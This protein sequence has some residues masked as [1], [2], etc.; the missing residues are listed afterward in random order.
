MSLI[1]W[2]IYNIFDYSITVE[3]PTQI[4]QAKKQL[5]SMY[6]YIEK[7]TGIP[8]SFIVAHAE[9]ES[10]QNPIARGALGEYGLW[11]FL[12]K[13]WFNLMPSTDWKNVN[14][15][16]Q[17]YIK[18][19]KWIISSLGLNMKKTT[20]REKFLWV[21]NAGIGNYRRNVLPRSTKSYIAKVL[22]L[23]EKIV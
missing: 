23:E 4:V 18:H 13:V 1:N 15:Q 19:A 22:N 12:P 10:N 9:A 21:W 20:D 6:R 16:A 8:Y 7:E 3:K 14:N 17:A 2:L 5:I 11:Q